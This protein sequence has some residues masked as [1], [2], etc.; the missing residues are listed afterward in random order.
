MTL[1][2]YTSVFAIAAL[3]VGMFVFYRKQDSFILNI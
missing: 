1:L 3:L 2:L